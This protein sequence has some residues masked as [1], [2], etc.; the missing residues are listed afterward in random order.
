MA[1][2]HSFGS[3]HVAAS[4]LLPP[5][6]TGC[7][8]CGFARCLAPAA[9]ASPAARRRAPSGRRDARD[10]ARDGARHWR[11]RSHPHPCVDLWPRGRG[12]CPDAARPTWREH[13]S[14]FRAGPP[15][16]A[17][18]TARGDRLPTSYSDLPSTA[19][20]TPACSAADAAAPRGSATRRTRQSRARRGRYPQ[21]HRRLRMKCAACPPPPRPSRGAPP[22]QA[23]GVERG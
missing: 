14:A 18:P 23:R 16:G 21:W 4:P 3:S 9:A 15:R 12:R 13:Q 7:R 11:R 8:G 19:A 10:C 2:S 1:T 5:T 17:A 6:A 20:T 22:S